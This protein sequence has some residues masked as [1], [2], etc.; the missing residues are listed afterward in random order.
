[1]ARLDRK[2]LGILLGSMAIAAL[3]TPEV[4]AVVLESEPNN[5]FPGQSANVD[6]VIAGNL[7]GAI[8]S[9]TPTNTADTIDFFHYTGL[10]TGGGYDLTFQSTA[11]G[12]QGHFLTAGRYTNQTTVASSVNAA[13]IPQHLLG[14]IPSGGE[15]S[16]GVT[17]GNVANF[18][19]YTLSL[20]VTPPTGVPEPATIVLV[21]AGL[22]AFGVGVAR[23]RKRD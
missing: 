9:A 22:T 5:T 4:E 7:C 13:Q 10:P 3:P 23:R 18:E 17:E 20:H 8:C 2:K 21:A 16:F 11:I 1:M 6:D 14:T 19:H 12:A 15:L